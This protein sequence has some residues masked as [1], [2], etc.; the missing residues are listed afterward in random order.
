MLGL[1][2]ESVG[3]RVM[4]A[5]TLVWRR[6]P[7]VKTLCSHWL[8]TA[9]RRVAAVAGLMLLAALP[10]LAAAEPVIVTVHQ[11]KLLRLQRP[12]KVVMIANPTIAD[13]VVQS[14]QLIFVLGLEPGETSLHILDGRGNVIRQ[15]AVVVVP[16]A[17][18]TVTVYRA[19]NLEE[20]TY[21]CAP[22]CATV[23]TA[24]GEGA[25]PPTGSGASD[26]TATA[27][28]TDTTA[29]TSETTTDDSLGSLP[30][31]PGG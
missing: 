7:V 8:G 28:A 21:S 30:S 9:R 23:G 19:N 24:V 3:P 10:A 1:I 13:V 20:A 31:L 2:V 5:V 12:A 4:I 14:P 29:T 26:T 16:T 15:S 18:R 6:D 22:R 27:E 25:A 11:A 17:E